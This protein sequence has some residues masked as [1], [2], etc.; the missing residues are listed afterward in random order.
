MRHAYRN[1]RDHALATASDR[2]RNLSVAYSLTPD[3]E[4][5]AETLADHI[6]HALDA[7]PAGPDSP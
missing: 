2:A 5:F 6:T 1:L 7:D 4:A 3:G